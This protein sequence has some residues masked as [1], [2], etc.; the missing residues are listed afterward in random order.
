MAFIVHT[1]HAP[2]SAS[3]VKGVDW[4]RGEGGEGVQKVGLQEGAEKV[5]ATVQM[6]V[7]MRAQGKGC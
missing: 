3:G 2:S 1:L 5:M 6:A 7:D 4:G